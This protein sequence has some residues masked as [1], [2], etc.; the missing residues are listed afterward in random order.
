MLFITFLGNVLIN[1]L[2]R[3]AEFEKNMCPIKTG[4]VTTTSASI[5]KL[6][7]AIGFK[8]EAPI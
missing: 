6:Q 4:G 1:Y 7:G 2:L 5:G 3:K 8:S